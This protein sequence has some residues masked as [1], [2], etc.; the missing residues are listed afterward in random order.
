MLS[1]L[2]DVKII[3]N[4]PNNTYCTFIILMFKMLIKKVGNFK[5]S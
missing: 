4:S 3:K 1:F 5:K 2:H